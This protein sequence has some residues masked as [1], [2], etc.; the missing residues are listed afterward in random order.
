M[1]DAD[2]DP[3]LVQHRSEAL[4]GYLLNMMGTMP[5]AWKMTY[6]VMIEALLSAIATTSG[7]RVG[8]DSSKSTRDCLGRPLALSF[9]PSIDLKV[10]FLTRDG[11]GVVWSAM[12]GAG[13]QERS[14]ITENR[15]IN[16]FRTTVSWTLTN[17]CALLTK[18]RLGAGKVLHLRYE[19]LC[20]DPIQSLRRIGDFVGEDLS[21]LEDILTRG[22]LVSAGHN[23][24]G[25]RLR[26]EKHIS[27]KCDNGWRRRMPS[28][29]RALFTCLTWPLLRKFG[30]DRST[31]TRVL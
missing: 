14:R 16:F 18:R 21:E 15:M 9:V 6:D 3:A 23:L 27:I 2:F 31:G 24:G 8:V 26:F 25:N 1:K 11:R 7:S 17:V 19:D 4:L 22:E 12:K 5:V 28:H 30:Y 10:I 13:S 20:A 29:Y